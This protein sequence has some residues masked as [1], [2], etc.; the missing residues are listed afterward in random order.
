MAESST[1]VDILE[2]IT[3]VLEN[4]AQGNPNQHNPGNTNPATVIGFNGLAEFKR[5]DP[6]KFEGGYNPDEAMRWLQEIEKILEAM[7]CPDTQ[8]V[9]YATFMLV[10]DAE[11]WW[12]HRQQLLQAEQRAITWAVFKEKFLEKYFPEDVRRKKEMEFLGLKQGTMSV[13]EYATI[14]E[15]VRKDFKVDYLIIIE[16]RDIIG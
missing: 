8:R 11:K 7:Q 12:K 14:N 1:N 13:G 9:I 16:Q 2:R 6:P 5:A 4:L 15:I 3:A 10:G